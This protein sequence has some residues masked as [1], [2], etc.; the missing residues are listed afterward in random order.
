M[1]KGFGAEEYHDLIYISKRIYCFLPGRKSR[2]RKKKDGDQLTFYCRSP[3]ED[4]GG[5]T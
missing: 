3:G 1:L 2:G 5:T 4:D